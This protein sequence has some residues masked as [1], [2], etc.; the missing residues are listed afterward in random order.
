MGPPITPLPAAKAFAEDERSVL[1][2]YLD[3]HRAVLVRKA[4]GITDA[5]ARLAA[6]PPSELTLLGLIRH[7]ADVERHW[8]RRALVG[9]DAP[10][11][12]YGDGHPDG[13][14][15]GDLHPTAE[16]TMA[17]AIAT[18]RA[19]LAGRS[20]DGYQPPDH[21]APPRPVPIW[22]GARGP[23]LLA[24]A[25]RAADGIFVSGCSPEQHE[26]VATIR[27]DA[28]AEGHPAVGVALY[29]SASDHRRD[30]SV[31]T[32]DDVGEVLAAEAARLATAGS[33]PAPPTSIGINLVDLLDP[34]ADP[35][36][37]VERAAVALGRR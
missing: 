9:E 36:A 16:D 10:P 37:A 12:Y 2:G 20:G 24:L 13:D 34:S 35:V 26:R 17:E 33:H 1:L 4:E 23:K 7:M 11:I 19:V 25:A 22:I 8:F 6:C 18:A 29:Q 32:W 30:A 27:A 14:P 15:D 3:Y 21:A 5:E 31:S 28:V